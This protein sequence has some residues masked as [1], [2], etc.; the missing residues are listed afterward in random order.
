MPVAR[1]KALRPPRRVGTLLRVLVP[2]HAYVDESSLPELRTYVLVAVVIP[3]NDLDE[4]RAKM[5]ELLLRPGKLHWHTESPARR[6]K[7][8]ASVAEFDHLN[9]VV[10]ASPTGTNQERARRL[11]LRELLVTL[12]GLGVTQVWMEARQARLNQGDTK[13]I[14]GFRNQRLIGRAL[15]VDFLRPLGEPALWLPDTI[16][17]AVTADL[18]GEGEYLN[19]L[20]PKI[21][22]I[23][24]EAR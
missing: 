1:L 16:A 23:R 3:T 5:R 6:R 19:T 22:L 4:V 15:R 7:I 2:L 8:V 9:V 11:C 18:H 14:G 10:I 20:G 12:E 24:I 13:T 17:G 21:H